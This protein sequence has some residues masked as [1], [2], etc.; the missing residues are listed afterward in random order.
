MWGDEACRV[1]YEEEQMRGANGA[2]G[3]EERRCFVADH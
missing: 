3:D 1:V 2:R